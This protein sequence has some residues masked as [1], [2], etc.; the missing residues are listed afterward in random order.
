MIDYTQW[1]RKT[2]KVSNLLLDPENPRI[3]PTE[4]ALAQDELL[5]ELVE[6]DHVY[7]LAKQISVKGYYADESLITA[8]RR[9]GKLVVVEGN[10]R[11]AALKALLSPDAVVDKHRQKFRALSA[12]IPKSMI[13]SVPI[14]IA[15]SRDVALPRVAEKHTRPLLEQWKPAQQAR[16]YRSLLEGGKSI[17]EICGN[18]GLT[19]GELTEFLRMDIL[20]QMA[21][22]LDLQEDVQRKVE[23]PRKFPI[24]NLERLLES[25]PGRNF[26]CVETDPKYGFKGRVPTTEFKR[27]FVKVVADVA[28]GNVTSR[29]L[30]DNNSIRAYLKTIEKYK[31]DQNKRGSFKSN[32]IIKKPKTPAVTMPTKQKR[33]PGH[34]LPRGLIPSDLKCGVSSQRVHNVFNELRRLKPVAEFRNAVA[35]MLRVFLELSVSH[36]IQQTGKTKNLLDIHAKQKQNR[37][38]WHPSLRQQLDF[39]LKQ[40]DL[41]LEPLE[42]KALNQF[43]SSKHTAFT[44]DSLDLFVHNKNAQPTEPELRA[45]WGKVESLFR[46]VLVEPTKTKN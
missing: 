43:L 15:P 29:D 45:I 44:L 5:A 9:D 8:P 14:I 39:M 31:P 19:E 22:S 1:E 28:E 3:P 11:L 16:F 38:D 2:A 37:P 34:R 6:H 35:I 41:P 24:T 30:N 20:Y 46:I 42:R 36:Y 32:D 33:T 27:G 40:M 25:Q 12:Q 17:K 26:L 23:N 4:N 7:D 18:Y 13:E 10:R 21:C